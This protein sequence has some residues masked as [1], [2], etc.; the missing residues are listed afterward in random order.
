MTKISQLTD[1]GGGL[2]AGDQFIV[3]D[4]SDGSTPNKRV[5]ASGFV[6]YVISQGTGAGFSQIAAGAGPLARVQTIASGTTGTVI[7]STASA[8]TLIERNRT[9][10]SGHYLVGITA[11][12]AAGAK[13]QTV[14]GITFPATQVASSDPNTLDDY[15]EGSWTPVIYD[16][17]NANISSSF[18]AT[19]TGGYYTRVGRLVTIQCSLYSGDST[20]SALIK[21]VEGLPFAS[22]SNNFTGFAMYFAHQGGANA[23]RTDSSATA[24]INNA[25]TIIRINNSISINQYQT[26]V[27]FGGFYY[28]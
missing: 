20:I 17:T 24:R 15:E 1:I 27:V 18:S 4:I 3:R 8:G 23:D 16:T 28:V 11:A 22:A 2:A 12:V 7:T 19:G 10:P 21:R 9:T 13:L 5:T 14:D 26:G 25:E 6:E